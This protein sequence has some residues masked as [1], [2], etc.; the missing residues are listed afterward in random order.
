MTNGTVVFKSAAADQPAEY[1]RF[2]ATGTDIFFSSA[3][4][5]WTGTSPLGSRNASG[6][7]CA[8]WTSTTQLG[9]Y[10]ELSWFGPRWTEDVDIHGFSATKPCTE[11]LRLY[12]FEQ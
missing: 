10:G 9:S 7:T 6:A 12:C 2:S 8:S 4:E 11:R 5:V 3:P 1:V